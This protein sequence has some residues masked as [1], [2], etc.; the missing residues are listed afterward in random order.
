[1]PDINTVF[2]VVDR[3]SGPIQTIQNNLS[4]MHNQLGGLNSAVTAFSS[5]GASALVGF[6]TQALAAVATVRTLREA[7]DFVS[8]SMDLANDQIEA[9]TKLTTVMQQRMNATSEEIAMIKE[10]AAE[11]QKLGVVGDEVALAGAQQ[12]ATFLNTSEALGALIPAMENLAAQQ[13]GANVTAENMVSIGNMM[14]KV[15][16]GQTSALSRVGI[17]FDEAQEQVLKYGTEIERANMLA[18]I[19]TQNVGNMNEALANTPEGQAQQLAHEWG[20]VKEV[21][22]TQVTPAY[23]ALLGAVREALPYVSSLLTLLG[24]GASIVMYLGTGA[25]M[26]FNWIAGG[27]SDLVGFIGDAWTLLAGENV[28]FIG[29]IMAGVNVGATGIMNLVLGLANGVI[30]IGVTTWNLIATF[31]NAFATVFNDPVAA[32]MILFEGLFDFISNVIQTAAGMIDTVLGTD[33]T[34]SLEAF[35]SSVDAKINSIIGD[36]Q[37]TVMQKAN[38]S[39]YLLK[40]MDYNQAAQ[41]GYE[42]GV[43]LRDSLKNAFVGQISDYVVEGA[44]G[45]DY[46]D[47]INDIANDTSNISKALDITSTQ[48]KYIFDLANRDA[49][50]RF[51]TAEV[52][53]DMTNYN[54]ISGDKD[55]EGV[56]ATLKST[57]LDEMASMAEGVH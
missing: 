2:A 34:G 41:E 10:L 16:Q 49:I 18:E 20:D 8:D 5:E 39:D 33:M 54:T 21:L 27:V 11:Q 55:T 31:A 32:I 14:G 23:M 47:Q 17:T 13:N 43:N 12:L 51:T 44:Y 26:V 4:G 56:V 45:P 24:Y 48:L 36:S 50:N 53:V 3:M 37:V 28:S 1:M 25:V 9:E 19:I 7:A 38:V 57:L 52:R 42:F 29:A 30:G 15:L 6:A 35:Q 40:G 22:G 46:G